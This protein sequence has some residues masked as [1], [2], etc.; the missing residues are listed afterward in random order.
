MVKW[1]RLWGLTFNDAITAQTGLGCGSG[2]LPLID[3]VVLGFICAS[4]IVSCENGWT[5]V[6]RNATEIVSSVNADWYVQLQRKVNSDFKTF[7]IFSSSKATISC[8]QTSFIFEKQNVLGNREGWYYL[9]VHSQW[10]PGCSV[11][12]SHCYD[13]DRFRLYS[14]DRSQSVSDNAK[15]CVQG[16][17]WAHEYQ[18]EDV[19]YPQVWEWISQSSSIIINKVTWLKTS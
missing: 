16:A 3:V 19:Q 5:P 13:F 9:L 17:S 2:K 6:A 12:C 1:Q 8:F 14:C 11:S 18:L 4:V 10:T 7:Y 15:A